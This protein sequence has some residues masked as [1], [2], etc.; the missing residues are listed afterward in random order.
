MFLVFSLGA[1]VNRNS[2]IF[3]PWGKGVVF[4]GFL[5]IT[6]TGMRILSLHSSNL[7]SARV[8]IILLAL[9]FCMQ[10]VFVLQS[11]QHFFKTLW[12]CE[13]TF[14]FGFSLFF[15]L[16]FEQLEPEM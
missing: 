3:G 16:A 1:L 4:C 2:T 5:S 13:I 10:N 8:K 15:L 6:L 9:G 14:R 7:S 12:L 11:L